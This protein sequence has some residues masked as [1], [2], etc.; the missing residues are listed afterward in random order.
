MCHFSFKLFQLQNNLKWTCSELRVNLNTSDSGLYHTISLMYVG[1][2]HLGF[3]T[4]WHDRQRRR[5]GLDISFHL[6]HQRH[7]RRLGGIGR[8]ASIELRV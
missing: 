8:V 2:R 7:D 6:I 3:G 4:T 5:F 1:A